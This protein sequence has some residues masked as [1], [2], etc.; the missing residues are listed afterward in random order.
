MKDSSSNT[1][2][3]ILFE[4]EEILV[5]DKPSGLMVHADGRSSEKNLVDWVKENYPALEGVGEETE[6]QSGEKLGRPGIVHRLD[7]ETSG[8][9]IIAKTQESFLNLKEQFQKHTALKVYRAF[10]RGR[11]KE[12]RG[13]IDRAIGKSRT[14][15]RL[16]SAQRHPKGTLREARTDFRVI[17]R[18]KFASYLEVFPKTGRTHQIRVHLKAIHHPV[19]CDDLYGPKDG[20]ELGFTRLALHAKKLTLSLLSGEE[21]TFEAPLP[22]EFVEAEQLLSSQG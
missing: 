9:M 14:N 3:I 2:P 1:N 20:C 16:W 4:N 11:I 18:T 10:V 22:R 17:A 13:V 19:L 12:D 6:L 5:I 7:R 21:R 15:F 8:V